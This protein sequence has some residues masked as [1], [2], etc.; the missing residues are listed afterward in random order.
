MKS[1]QNWWA[2]CRENLG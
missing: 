2:S 1:K